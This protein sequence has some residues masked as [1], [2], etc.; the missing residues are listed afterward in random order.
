MVG[1]AVKR[2]GV[3]P[4]R[5]TMGLSERRA[6][7]I[8]SAD[9]K[10][11]RYRSCRPP[12]TELR[13]QLRDLANERKRFGYRR[14]FV[15]LRQEGEPSG[16]NRIDRLYREEGLTVRKRR[17]RRRAVGS[18]APIL[19]E[20]KP[21]ARWSVDFVHDQLACGR[22]LRILNI[23]DDGTR[24]CLAAIPDTSIPGRRVARELTA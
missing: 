9:R 10:M 15:L 13:T 20:S 8:V 3:A 2:E 24:E 7:S 6:G 23:V 16:I 19:V 18:R 11:I 17:A 5:A 1:P 12:D 14:L 4:L 22:R 21:N